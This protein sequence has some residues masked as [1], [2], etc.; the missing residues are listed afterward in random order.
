MERHEQLDSDVKISLKISAY[1]GMRLCRSRIRRR[2]SLL[3]LPTRSRRCR[4]V[5]EFLEEWRQGHGTSPPW[6]AAA[7]ISPQVDVVGLVAGVFDLAVLMRPG[8]GRG[9]RVG[10]GE[11]TFDGQVIA[12]GAFD[13]DDDVVELVLTRLT[14][15]LDGKGVVRCSIPEVWHQGDVSVEVSEPPSRRNSWAQST[16]TMPKWVGPTLNAAA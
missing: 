5:A 6:T 10:V 11:G 3:V 1:P 14:N 12:A 15:R 4:P 13:D 2:R 8:R 9:P 7:Q 16:A